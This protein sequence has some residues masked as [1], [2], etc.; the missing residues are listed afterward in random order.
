MR[1]NLRI[2]GSSSTT[3]I[4]AIACPA[5]PPLI[6]SRTLAL[7]QLRFGRDRQ[8]DDDAGAGLVQARMGRDRAAM[9]FHDTTAD[10]KAQPSSGSL[11]VAGLDAVEHVEDALAVLL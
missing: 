2:C 9:R 11:T 1:R 7:D 8:S 3:R 10:R 6:S 4:F 5:L